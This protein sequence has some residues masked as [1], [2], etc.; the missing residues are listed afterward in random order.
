M[1]EKTIL[2]FLEEEFGF[3]PIESPLD[4]AKGTAMAMIMGAGRS[5][6]GSVAQLKGEGFTEVF[7]PLGYSEM[8][9]QDDRT[10]VVNISS[11]MGKLAMLL[12]TPTLMMVRVEGLRFLDFSIPQDRKMAEEYERAITQVSANDAGI[13]IASPSGIVGPP[14]TPI[15]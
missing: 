1:P 14:V 4:A 2:D 6:I 9:S 5:M 7:Y 12:R 11:Q 13:E 8:A 10:G 3:K 15:R